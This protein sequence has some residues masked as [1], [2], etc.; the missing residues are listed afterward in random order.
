MPHPTAN[1]TLVP[2]PGIELVPPALQGRFSTTRPPGKPLFMF[3]K[4]AWKWNEKKTTWLLQMTIS[5]RKCGKR[6][7]WQNTHLRISGRGSPALMPVHVPFQIKGLLSKCKLIYTPKSGSNQESTQAYPTG[8]YAAA[9]YPGDKVKHAPIMPTHL[10]NTNSNF[11][12]LHYLWPKLMV[13]FLDMLQRYVY[14]AGVQGIEELCIFK[15]I[16]ENM[17]KQQH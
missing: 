8:R 2:W 3:L 7:T 11:W 15:I 12:L 6:K 9:V 17:R 5:P 16:I 14:G 1:G 13:T 4:E 10:P